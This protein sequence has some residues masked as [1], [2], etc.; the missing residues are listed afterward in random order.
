MPRTDYLVWPLR[1]ATSSISNLNTDIVRGKDYMI[2]KV[3]HIVSRGFASPDVVG[4]DF[5]REHGSISEQCRPVWTLVSRRAS[6]S[7][8][9]LWIFTVLGTMPKA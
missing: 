5:A 7:Q 1:H 6:K 3:Q 4:K 2:A 8:S 9:A